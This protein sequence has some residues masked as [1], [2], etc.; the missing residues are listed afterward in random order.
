M[1]LKVHGLAKD[2][3]LT[4][5]CG[6]PPTAATKRATLWMEMTNRTAKIRT[7][8]ALGVVTMVNMTVLRVVVG[9]VTRTTRKGSLEC[10]R[11]A[12]RLDYIAA[13]IYCC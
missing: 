10:L 11:I 13:Y 7:A 5:E 1:K 9:R 4:H 2:F 8:V 6:P 12:N 3:I